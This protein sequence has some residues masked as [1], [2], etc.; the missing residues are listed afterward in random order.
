MRPLQDKCEPTPY[1]DLEGLFLSDMGVPV[2][3]LFEDFDPEPIG[4]ASLA[5]VH[6]GRHR[7]SRKQVAVK[8]GGLLFMDFNSYS[9]WCSCN[10]RIL[11]NSVTL[12]W[13]WLKSPLVSLHQPFIVGHV[14]HFQCRLDKILV[15]RV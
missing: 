5:Q 8:V 4:V 14:S 6:V 12:I 2:S 9:S 10:I 11:Q 3:E 7:E 15:S 13:R 1:E